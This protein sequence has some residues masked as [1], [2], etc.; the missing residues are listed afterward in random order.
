MLL[1]QQSLLRFPKS[2][3]TF[4]FPI[5][6]QAIVCSSRKAFPIHLYAC[7]NYQWMHLASPLYC[8]VLEENNYISLYSHLFSLPAF[9]S[10]CSSSLPTF[11]VVHKRWLQKTVWSRECPSFPHG[12][13]MSCCLNSGLCAALLLFYFSFPF[14]APF[15]FS[16][17]TPCLF[18]HLYLGSGL[19]LDSTHFN[20]PCSLG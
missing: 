5:F 6:P 2:K 8:K 11:C 13:T 4:L 7:V 17:I 20:I 3:P 10:F 1:P 9:W 14:L 18:E 12:R 15:W 19:A 16:D